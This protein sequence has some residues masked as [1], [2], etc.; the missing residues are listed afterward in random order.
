MH[1]C[2]NN[3]RENELDKTHKNGSKPID[4]IAASSGMMERV[5][6]CQSLD[7]NDTVESDHHARVIDVDI[8]E[9]F[10]EEFSGWDDVNRAMLNPAKRS[11]REKFVE[12]IVDQ[13]YL[14]QIEMN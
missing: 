10:Q 13:L 1:Q 9:H 2:A 11:H 12:S 5:E 14:H 4:S 6:G 3:V 7:H 8:E